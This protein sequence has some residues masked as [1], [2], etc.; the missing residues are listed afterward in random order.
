MSPIDP[1][2]LEFDGRRRRA[3]TADAASAAR[4]A[5]SRR[6]A[7]PPLLGRTFAPGDAAGDAVV[8]SEGF[9]L[10]RLGG[11]PAAVGR[12][13][14]LDGNPPCD[15][16]CRAAGFSFSATGRATFSSPR[17]S[18]RRS[19]ANHRSYV[20]WLVGKLRA[21]VTLETAQTEMNAIALALEVDY[22]QTGRGA[23]ANLV[24][25]HEHLIFE[26]RPMM[27]ALIGAVAFVLLIACANVANLM[28][29][30]ATTRQRSSR[31]AK[32][33]VRRAVEC[34]GSSWPRAAC[35][36]L[37][38]RRRHPDRGRLASATRAFDSGHVSREHVGV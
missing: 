24:P 19:L 8:V 21:G 23:A 2:T 28:L 32:L 26:L 35:S 33:W 29:A 7:L 25:L 11:D 16:R 31:F 22:P 30:R 20:W 36:Q 12:T 10:R 13:I 18:R 3:G 14:T 15:R 9:W 34:C 5:C 38:C 27:L 6:S 37:G 4:R 17:C 1:V